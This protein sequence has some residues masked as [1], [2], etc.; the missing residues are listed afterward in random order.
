M[1]LEAG[2]RRLPGADAGGG[3]LPCGVGRCDRYGAL[4]WGSL[5]LSAAPIP[6]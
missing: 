4:P 6:G 3:L 5:P 2:G 1:A